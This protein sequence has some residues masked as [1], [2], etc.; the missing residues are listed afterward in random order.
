MVLVAATAA[1]LGLGRVL[2]GSREPWM[3]IKV[4]Y[5]VSVALLW[6][7]ALLA[8]NFTRYRAPVRELACRPGFS[9]GIAII[10]ERLVAFISDAIADPL[11]WFLEPTISVSTLPDFLKQLLCLC[12]GS[13]VRS[14][15]C[16]GVVAAVWLVTAMAG[17]WRPEKTWLDRTGR[18]LGVFWLLITIAY[19][20]S[21]WAFPA[22]V[23]AASPFPEA[24]AYA[25]P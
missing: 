20:V 14:G 7:L 4:N 5:A 6:T 25:L 3:D 17:C 18:A 9:A 2:V 12:V 21:L 8:L 24:E 13:A 11:L 23:P 10:V 16:T 22:P 15:A 1:G 19:W